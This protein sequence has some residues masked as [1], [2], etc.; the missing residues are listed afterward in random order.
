MNLYKL[1]EIQSPSKES[2]LRV[3]R[4]RNQLK[5]AQVLIVH[6]REENR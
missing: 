1:I 4:L 3:K 5:E 2:D 6:L